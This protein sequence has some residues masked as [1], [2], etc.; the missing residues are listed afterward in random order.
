MFD[1]ETGLPFKVVGSYEI[2]PSALAVYQHNFG[3][4][5]TTERNIMGLNI[6][7][8]EDLKPNLLV[9]SPPC[10]PFTR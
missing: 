4:T 9:M 8:L 5:K 10:Q 7:T 6:K 3:T 2:N 1:T